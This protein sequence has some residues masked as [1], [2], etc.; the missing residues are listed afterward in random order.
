MREKVRKT[1]MNEQKM[2]LRNAG[3]VTFFF[4]GIC[5]IST[6]VVVSLLQ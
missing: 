3:F 6:G 1:R 2:R 5:A 4:S